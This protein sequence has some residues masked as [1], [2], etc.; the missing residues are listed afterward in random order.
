[1][2]ADP[3]P[4]VPTLT[5]GEVTLRGF[6]TADTDAVVAYAGDAQVQRWTSVP[7]PYGRRDAQS[8]LATHADHWR[9]GGERGFAVETDGRWAGTLDLRPGPARVAEVG[10]GLAP[11]ARGRGVMARA[12]RLALA[13]GFEELRLDLV[14]WQAQVGNWASRRVAWAV[15][16]DVEAR[17]TGGLE[18]R[19]RRADS[20]YGVLRRGDP[21]RPRRPWLE[22]VRLA[23]R[24]VVLRAHRDDDAERMV[25]ACRDP[26]TQHWLPRLPR[27]YA[28][29][30]ARQHIER[31]RCDAAAGR[32]LAWAMADPDDDR[33][34]GEIAL[35]LRDPDAGGPELG[36]WAHPDARGRGVTTEAARLAVRHAMLPWE[37][38]GLGHRRV[39]LRAATGNRAS[40]RVAEGAGMRRTGTDRATHILGDGTVSD[41]ARFDIVASEL[42]ASR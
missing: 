2:T 10:F 29:T 25:Q 32:V 3:L 30:H 16:F 5:D 13:W 17:L 6:R 38:G 11:W 1:V 26:A 14:Q 7:S 41:D 18:H 31:L 23:G 9:R 39:S 12:L 35:A 21:M 8:F 42:P 34:V 15:G 4:L 33:L 20:W 37:D 19:G 36:Y 28:T 27:D 24:R 40:Q 22:P